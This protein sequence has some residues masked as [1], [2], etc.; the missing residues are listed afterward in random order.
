[1]DRGRRDRGMTFGRDDLVEVGD[2][3]PGGIKAVDGRLLLGT[4][5]NSDLGE[6]V[7]I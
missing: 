6:F 1:M 2:D 5:K 3:V 7:R 4:S